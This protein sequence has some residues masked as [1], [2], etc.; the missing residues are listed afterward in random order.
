MALEEDYNTTMRLKRS[1]LDRLNSFG[2]KNESND[3]LV[4]R[5]LDTVK[6]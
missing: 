2:K 1:T 3:E 5:L 4:N 6:N